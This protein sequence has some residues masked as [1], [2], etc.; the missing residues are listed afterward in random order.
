MRA[1]DGWR[2]ATAVI[3]ISFLA[4]CTAVQTPDGATPTAQHSPSRPGADRRSGTHGAETARQAARSPGPP[5]ASGPDARLAAALAPLLRHQAA[6]LAVGIVD[7]ATDATAGYYASRTFDAASIVKADILAVL[8][9]QHEQIGA[10]LSRQQQELAAWLAATSRS[11]RGGA[12]R[13]AAATWPLGS[14]MTITTA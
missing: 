7:Q 8:L 9:L 2:R 13:A 12:R 14:P 11:V 5:R 3:A 10:P 4:A 1:A 6:S